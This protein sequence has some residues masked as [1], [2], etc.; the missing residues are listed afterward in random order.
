M[1]LKSLTISENTILVVIKKQN[2][3][4]NNIFIN[5]K[6]LRNQLIYL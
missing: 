4:I 6:S 3:D 1:I 5:L 2:I